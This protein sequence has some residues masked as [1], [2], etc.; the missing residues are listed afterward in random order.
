MDNVQKAIDLAA[1]VNSK[2]ECITF[3]Q[4]RSAR[5]IC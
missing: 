5:R 2:V 4:I 1:A 3:E